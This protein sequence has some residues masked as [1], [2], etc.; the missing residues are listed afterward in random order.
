M[1]RKAVLP[2]G[3]GSIVKH[4]QDGSFR[5][6]H[7]DL[8]GKIKTVVLYSSGKNKIYKR[9][10]AEARAY[11]LWLERH[12]LETLETK[13]EALVKIAETKKM[14]SRS[15]FKVENVWEAFSGNPRNQN[16][17]LNYR[18]T[19]W[20]RFAA[21]LDRHGIRE[22]ALAD[23]ATAQ[24]FL[25]EIRVSTR[26]ATYNDYITTLRMMFRQIMAVAGLDSNPF[27]D[28]EKLSVNDSEGHKPFSSEMVEKIEETIHSGAY[29][30]MT[31]KAGRKQPVPVS[32][33][34]LLVSIGINTGM[35][36]KDAVL[37]NYDEDIDFIQNL[38]RVKPC[39]TVRYGKRIVIPI[40][41]DLN[42]LLNRNGTGYVLPVMAWNYLNVGNYT[43]VDE[44]QHLL[45]CSGL[46]INGRKDTRQELRR[47]NRYGFHSFRHSFASRC[48]AHG[49]PM[50]VVEAILG[51]DSEVIKKYYTHIGADHIK[52]SMRKIDGARRYSEEE[53]RQMDKD[54]LVKLILKLQ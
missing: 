20:E 27:A 40:M 19:Q 18:K 31:V 45:K 22:L 47:T 9:A 16:S 2:K 34:R 41:N 51:S 48:A 6:Q 42:D 23:Q 46:R 1:A 54:E 21:Y 29:R 26:A 33:M 8:D 32:E 53:L 12:K 24:S 14:I 50:A 36:L 17:R 43:A 37:L 3:A 15:T 35:R 49:V 11:E 13:A 25:N 28:I 7:K 30:P 52:S 4:K 38:V 10:E 39:K 5:Y 44:I